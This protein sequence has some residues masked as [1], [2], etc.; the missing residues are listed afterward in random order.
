MIEQSLPKFFKV[1]P[2]E[3]NI[4]LRN[5][6]IKVTVYIFYRETKPV[7]LGSNQYSSSIPEDNVHSRIQL[8]KW[9][10]AG[11]SFV[12][13]YEGDIYYYP[14]PKQNKT[15][16]LTSSARPGIIY[17]GIPD[18]LYEGLQVFCIVVYSIKC[19]NEMV[20]SSFYNQDFRN[21]CYDVL[22]IRNYYWQNR[23]HIYYSEP[24]SAFSNFSD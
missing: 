13:V 8:V 23:M 10:P 14:N 19:N 1:F 15:F 11:H 16:R 20:N 21:V 24:P 18:W 2:T 22:C 12:F 3:K 9:S 4:Y 17:N 6:F 7:S 5:E